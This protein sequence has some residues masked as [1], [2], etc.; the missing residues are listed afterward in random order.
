RRRPPPL[1][2]RRLRAGERDAGAGVRQGD[3]APDLVP[4]PVTRAGAAAADGRAARGRS[5][6]QGRAAASGRGSGTA[7][8]AG[9][10]RGPASRRSGAG[11]HQLARPARRIA[12]GTR[13]ARI[14]VASASTATATPTPSICTKTTCAVPYAAKERARITPAAVISGPPWRSPAAT[15]VSVSPVRRYSSVIRESR[16]T[17]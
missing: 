16:N 2:A 6:R 15:A 17:S 4:R 14:T 13:I 12:A 11:A 10:G 9:P 3:G 8:A 1:P 5:R 7:A